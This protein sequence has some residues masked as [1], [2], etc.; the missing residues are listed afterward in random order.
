MMMV[1]AGCK[2]D[3]EPVKQPK[4]SVTA[5]TATENSV[6]FTVTPT[7]A[8][9]CA[10]VCLEASEAVPA[11][12][13]ILKDGVQIDAAK[14]STQTVE[15]LKAETSYNIVAAVQ[16]G[17]LSAVSTT[18]S[19][20]T[21]KAEEPDKPGPDDP[22][23]P[24][25]DDPDKPDEGVKPQITIAVSEITE[26]SAILTI[27]P[28]DAEKCA[29]LCLPELDDS[30]AE[31]II[32][33][34][35]EADA[36]KEAEYKL[37]SLKY[38]TTYNVVAAVKN[39]NNYAKANYKFT[40]KDRTAVVNEYTMN[41]GVSS[42]SDGHVNVVLSGDNVTFYL[43]FYTGEKTV[44]AGYYLMKNEVKGK[45]LSAAKTYMETKEGRK[46][47]KTGNATVELTDKTYKMTFEFTDEIGD[48]FKGTFSGEIS[49]MFDEEGGA[50]IDPDAK[51]IDIAYISSYEEKGVF[52]LN[53]YDEGMATYQAMIAMYGTPEDIFLQPGE[54][55]FG[56]ENAP[57]TFGGETS[58]ISFW[59]PYE[60]INI[61]GGKVNVKLTGH[62]YELV[63]NIQGING[64][65]YGAKYV[66]E[67]D[68]MYF[69]RIYE[70][71]AFNAAQYKP[72][73]QAQTG[74][75]T[76]E[77][78]NEAGDVLQMN[79]LTGKEGK[80]LQAGSYG[81]TEFGY[82][83]FFKPA[84]ASEWETISLSRQTAEV[85]LNGDVYTITYKAKGNENVYYTFTFNGTIASAPEA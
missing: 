6:S 8:E 85:E 76:I 65:K 24:G 11:A 30:P 13:T 16:N 19:M 14:E 29:Y 10:Y 61:T 7:D 23:K 50:T 83:S 26:D 81:E 74:E 18:L 55:T 80:T 44:P 63:F 3:P 1:F 71:K 77:M 22:D 52:T 58:T 45:C 39:G 57:F 25:P 66:G 54:Y 70:E 34:G 41:S 17:E 21:L 64:K 72:N 48:I 67:I 36:T 49:G 35:N 75:F 5:G 56:K 27:S 2:E 82:G 79:I 68:G 47:F 42:S 32:V 33:Y 62:V 9:R 59:N 84:G 37:Q 4:V 51:V 69:E 15:N 43:D 73:P 20:T 78:T 60:Y 28:V 46:T 31:E 40:T 12:E 38:N 53:F